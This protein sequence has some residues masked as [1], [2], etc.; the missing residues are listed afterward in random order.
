MAE[1]A[2]KAPQSSMGAQPGQS[3]DPIRNYAWKILIGGQQVG[4]FIL[5]SGIDIAVDSIDYYEGGSPHARRISGRVSYAPITLEYGLTPSRDIW[6]WMQKSVKQGPQ[7]AERKNL[8]I[9]ML[10]PDGNEHLLQWNLYNA[11]PSRLKAKPMDAA[12]SQFLV[13]SLELTF[14]YAEQ[15]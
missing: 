2:Q 1:A 4:S 5:C 12:L 9:V 10:G 7:G 14:D 15:D 13:V 8:S 11:W 3:V 6:D